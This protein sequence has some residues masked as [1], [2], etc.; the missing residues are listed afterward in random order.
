[1]N[2]KMISEQNPPLQPGDRVQWVVWKLR[3][4]V[5]QFGF[6]AQAPHAALLVVTVIM[7]MILIKMMI[8]M[9]MFHSLAPQST[10]VMMTKWSPHSEVWLMY[11]SHSGL[12]CILLCYPW[13][14]IKSHHYPWTMYTIGSGMPRKCNL[15]KVCLFSGLYNVEHDPRSAQDGRTSSEMW[16][17]DCWYLN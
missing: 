9:I 4:G 2:T 11:A 3:P 13:H 16:S 5:P 8:V 6:P 12:G 17:P 14:Y 15:M 10:V 7:M 1:M